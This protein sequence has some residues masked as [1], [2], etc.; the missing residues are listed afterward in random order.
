[1]LR[2]KNRRI[3]KAVRGSFDSGLKVSNTLAILLIHIVKQPTYL[4]KDRHVVVM[5]VKLFQVDLS[6]LIVR[7]CTE[8]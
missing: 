8:I 6:I 3:D 4:S 5:W 7:L 2:I 1:M